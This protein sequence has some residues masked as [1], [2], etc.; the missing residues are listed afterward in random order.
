MQF[1]KT[2]VIGG[3]VFLIPIVVLIAVL[4]KALEVTGAIASP[5]A[6]RFPVETIGTFAVSHLLALVILVLICFAAGLLARTTAAQRLIEGLENRFLSKLPP[7]ALLKAKTQSMLSP[8][9]VE[10]MTPVAVRFD[11]SWQIAFEIE[12]LQ[13]DKVALFLPG[14]PDPW[15]GT[16]CVVTADRVTPLDVSIPFI[17]KLEK[18]LGRG[19]GDALAGS[20]LGHPDKTGIAV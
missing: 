10:G 6:A 9:D 3:I 11:D 4:G 13:G 20:T 17:A 14:A 15:A 8:E 12:R 18:R 7:Y 5:L 1:V 19:A 2:T 16:V